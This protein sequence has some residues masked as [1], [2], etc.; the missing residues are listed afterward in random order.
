MFLFRANDQSRPVPLPILTI[1]GP[2]ASG[3]STV[4][5]LLGERFRGAVLYTGKHYRAATCALL[6]VG[7]ALDD[8]HGA[9]QALHRLKPALNSAGAILLDGATIPDAD[10]ESPEVEAW[11]STVAV[12]DEIRELL[13]SLQRDFIRSNASHEHPIVV[14]GR[15]AGTALAPHAPARFFLDCSVDERALR[16][17]RQRGLSDAQRLEIAE[18]LNSRDRQDQGHGR[19]T[20]DTPGLICI[21]TD[22]MPA[23]AVVDSIWTRVSEQVSE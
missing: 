11:V 13:R 10:A 19:A 15:D 22:G 6:D 3:K 16:R 2:S 12:N 17:G 7:V 8:E 20:R 9:A 23:L 14:E 18:R 1:D 5:A 21:L 4:A